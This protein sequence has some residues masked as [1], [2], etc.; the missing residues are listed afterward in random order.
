M[1][2]LLAK[3]ETALHNEFSALALAECGRKEVARRAH[4]LISEAGLLG[5][6]S[7]AEVCRSLETA[8]QNGASF[9]E[10]LSK[11]GRCRLLVLATME[12]LKIES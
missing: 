5:F 8:C 9:K 3:L 7:M 1:R 10:A 4:I 11:L 6:H 2:A 12:A